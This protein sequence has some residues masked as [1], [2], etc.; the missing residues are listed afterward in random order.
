MDNLVQYLTEGQQ[1]EIQKAIFE[2]VVTQ[3]K[4][5]KFEIDIR[6]ILE[7]EIT[8]NDHVQYKRSRV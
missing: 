6:E 1:Q 4:S 3:I 7:E 8:E 2:K 5:Q